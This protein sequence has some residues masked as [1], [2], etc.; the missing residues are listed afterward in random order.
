MITVQLNEVILKYMVM[1]LWKSQYPL[2]LLM[3]SE[4]RYKYHITPSRLPNARN[5]SENARYN[6]SLLPEDR[7]KS[8]KAKCSTHIAVPP[9]IDNTAVNAVS[10][11]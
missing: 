7:R 4:S 6:S 10:P 3:M 5:A 8:L 1:A 11:T 9:T 2:L